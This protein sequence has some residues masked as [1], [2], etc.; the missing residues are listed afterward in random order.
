MT[1]H[2]DIILFGDTSD[3]SPFRKISL[4]AKVSLGCNI[5]H[6]ENHYPHTETQS[7]NTCGE[8]ASPK[9]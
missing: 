4:K 8:I 9:P 2:R 6:V 7:I 5:T 3:G 1:T